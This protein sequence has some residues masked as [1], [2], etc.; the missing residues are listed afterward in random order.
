MIQQN[1]RR[2]VWCWPE[3]SRTHAWIVQQGHNISLYG[4]HKPEVLT[5]S[6]AERRVQAMAFWISLTHRNVVWEFSQHQWSGRELLN[7]E[8]AD[9]NCL[10]NINKSGKKNVGETCNTHG[11][12]EKN[13]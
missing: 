7:E 13:T 12:E 10:E 3:E 2:A 1:A 6:Q 8:M 5:T 11:G 4:L 9:L